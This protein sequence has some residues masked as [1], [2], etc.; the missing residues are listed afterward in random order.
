MRIGIIS[1]THGFLDPRVVEIFAG[2]DHIIHAGDI[3]DPEIL[4]ELASV[5][6]VTAVSGNIDSGR[7]AAE[8]PSEATGDIDGIRFVV[9]HKPKRLQ[10]RLGAGKIDFGK[11]GTRPDLVVWGHVHAPSVAW[12]EGTL[13]LN[14]GTAASPYEEDDDPTIA[15]V[16]STPTGL[17]ARL[18][19][20]DR[21]P[22]QEP[23]D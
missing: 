21:R 2:V 5:A 23:S 3:A 6:P 10:K 14:P 17:A 4:S 20:L 9:A 12:I 19:P 1:D 7:L 11:K 22:A 18:I 15:I 16:E 13:H 8:L